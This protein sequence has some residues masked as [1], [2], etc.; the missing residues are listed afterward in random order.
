[1]LAVWLLDRL[2]RN[3]KDLLGLANGLETKRVQFITPTED[4]GTTNQKGK[5]VFQKFG[6]LAGAAA[7]RA[8]VEVRGAMTED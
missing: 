5:L 7:A 6:V 3:F 8:R 1:M 4:M 2:G